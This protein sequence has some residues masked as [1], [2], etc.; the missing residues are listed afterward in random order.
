MPWV[1]LQFFDVDLDKHSLLFKVNLQDIV[2][3]KLKAL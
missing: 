3:L 2:L 1:F